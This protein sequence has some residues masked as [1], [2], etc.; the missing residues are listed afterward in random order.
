M[1]PRPVVWIPAGS[2]DAVRARLARMAAVGEM[3]GPDAR[4]DGHAGAEVVVVGETPHD[5]TTFF[6]GIGGLQVIQALSA[7]VDSLVGHVPRGVTLCDAAGAYDEAVAE[8]VLMAILAARRDL[9][10]YVHAQRARIWRP[11]ERVGAHVEARVGLA[12][13]TVLIIGYGS[14]GRALERRL[15]ACGMTVQR[16]AR[17]ARPGVAAM[18]DARGFLP[19]ADVV[20]LLVPLTDETRGMVDRRFLAAMATDALLVNAARGAIVDTAALLGELEA[21]RLTAALDVTEPEPLP[22]G[23][24]LWSAPGVIITPHVAGSTRQAG[25][26]AWS[27]ATAQVSRYRRGV[28]LRNVVIDG[29]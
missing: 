5:P 2:P 20:V 8:W 18:A 4:P 10:G 3:P 19:G 7:G 24:P 11:D 25:L 22:D 27:I 21:G 13:G 16:V 23:H 12:G 14:I 15:A 6:G 26:R 1:A 17:R 9:P 29:Y 28:P